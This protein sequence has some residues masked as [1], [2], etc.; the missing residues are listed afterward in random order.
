MVTTS[1]V[2]CDDGLR[3]TMTTNQEIPRYYN[4][5]EKSNYHEKE[6]LHM[7]IRPRAKIN[8]FIN[9]NYN[10]ITN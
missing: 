9:V 3:V 2:T 5:Y 7:D 4:N 8:N 1:T 6:R 10:I